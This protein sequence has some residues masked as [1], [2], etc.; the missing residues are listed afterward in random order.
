MIETKLYTALSGTTNITDYAGTRIYP[1]AL[2]QEP[3]YPAIVYTRTSGGQVNDLSGYAGLEN[4]QIGI[5]VF[6][7]TYNAAKALAEKVHTVLNTVTT[8]RATL[9]NDSDNFEAEINCYRV[10][11]DFSCWNKE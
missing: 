2:P 8:F 5:D 1:V 4:P 11:M 10:A 7:E 3:T 9:T 6:A